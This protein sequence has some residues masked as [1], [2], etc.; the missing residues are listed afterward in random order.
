MVL[1]CLGD[2]GTS[3]QP[4]DA[5]SYV[6]VFTTANI[7]YG[8]YNA[9]VARLTT[10]GWHG[11]QARMSYTYSKALDNASSAGAPFIPGPLMTQVSSACPSRHGQSPA[12][13]AGN[14]LRYI[15]AAFGSLWSGCDFRKLLGIDRTTDCRRQHHRRWPGAGYPVHDSP[16]AVQLPDQRLRA[17]RF[18]PDQSFHPGVH[19][20]R[21]LRPA[22]PCG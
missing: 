6:P 12:I 22:G 21:S 7:G 4:C 5:F 2:R 3:T 9:F 10:R 20:G 19:V 17:I 18:R 1:H 15:P 8:N 16:G 11:F 14:Q 13:C